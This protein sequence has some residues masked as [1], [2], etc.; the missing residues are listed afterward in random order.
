MFEITILIAL[1]K[2][3]YAKSNF[4]T[5]AIVVDSFVVYIFMYKYFR[6]SE[7]ICIIK[8]SI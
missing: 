2:I 4:V 3:T 5:L 8:F 1:R 7:R 6:H